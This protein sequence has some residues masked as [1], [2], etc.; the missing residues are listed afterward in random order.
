MPYGNSKQN[1]TVGRFS[2]VALNQFAWP[3][4]N[5]EE[6]QPGRVDGDTVSTTSL[7]NDRPSGV[8]WLVISSNQMENYTVS[9]GD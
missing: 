1:K 7:D 2:G 8:C 9:P 5:H 3:S 4:V 6:A